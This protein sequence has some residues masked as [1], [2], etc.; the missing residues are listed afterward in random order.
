MPF[1][2]SPAYEFQNIQIKAGANGSNP[3]SSV[4]IDG[5][6][7]STYRSDADYVVITDMSS[8]DTLQLAA[9]TT[10]GGASDSYFIGTAPD[11]FHQYNIHG[12]Q[13]AP[14]ALDFGIYKVTEAGPNLVAEVKGL[15]LG[16]N[17]TVASI[18]GVSVDG[19]NN[20]LGGDT[21]TTGTNNAFA[22]LGVGAMYNLTGSNFAS[23]VTFA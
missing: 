15:A 22:Y 10:P 19:Q 5:N 12:S 1:H 13:G 11:G 23:H 20:H 17:L 7:Y 14:S 16:G 9:S 4:G 6:G 8:P 18:G 2:S 3:G 21:T